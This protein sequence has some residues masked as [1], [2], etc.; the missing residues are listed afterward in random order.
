[1][2][3]AFDFMTEVRDA[4]PLAAQLA[5]DRFVSRLGFDVSEDWHL[6]PSPQGT[7]ELTEP[8]TRIEASE[9][10]MRWLAKTGDPLVGWAARQSVPFI[11]HPQR[12]VAPKGSRAAELIEASFEINPSKLAYVTPSQRGMRVL[13][14]SSEM[15]LRDL[16][17][18]RKRHGALIAMAAG[19]AEARR[20]PVPITSDCR[21]TRREREVMSWLASGLRNARIAERMGIS[22]PTVEMH[23][24]NARRK[25]RALT[26]EQALVEA[27]RRGL[28]VP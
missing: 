8:R 20:A 28:I 26:R 1:M 19:I 16:E 21:L 14:I 11:I 4:D 2:H 23:L 15:S 6:A 18:T 22:L 13:A 5:F 7:W 24:A 10:G 3:Q 17:A 27:V 25:L 12:N 9:I